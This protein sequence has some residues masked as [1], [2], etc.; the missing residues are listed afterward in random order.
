[1]TGFDFIAY[2]R[3]GMVLKTKDRRDARIEAV[4]AAAGSISGLVQMFGPCAW[5]AAGRYS[6]APAGAAG[7]LDLAIPA[8]METK[9][10]DQASGS[11]AEALNDPAARP[12][13][14]D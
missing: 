4:D 3:P 12:F 8:Q 2:C 1:M 14:C 6:E 11:L 5:T 10:A 7:P 13:C 9:I